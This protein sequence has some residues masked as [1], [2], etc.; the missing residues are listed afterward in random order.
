MAWESEFYLFAVMCSK[1]CFSK[2]LNMVVFLFCVSE[3]PVLAH[4]HPLMCTFN[5]DMLIG[6]FFHIIVVLNFTKMFI[7]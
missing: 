7:L 6:M 1:G 2:L 3:D 4:L 5:L